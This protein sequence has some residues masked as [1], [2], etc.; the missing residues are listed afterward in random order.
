MTPVIVEPKD[1]LSALKWAVSEMDRRYKLFAEVGVKNIIGY[2][3]MSGFSALPFLLIVI[4]EL[5]DIMHFAPAEVEDTI[6]RIAQM[7]RATGIHLVISTQRPSVDVITGLIKANISCRLAFNVSSQIDSRVILDTPG[8]EK[9]LG[10]GDMLFI[11]PDQ[12]K[13]SRIQGTFIS[14]KE[15]QALIKFIKETG[16]TPQYTDEV[17][18]MADKKITPSGK[19]TSVEETERDEFFNQAVE[20]I[21]RDKRASASLFQR[22][23]K[24]GYARAARIIDQLEAAGIVGAAEGSKSREILISSPQDYFN[25]QQNES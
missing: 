23:L 25:R 18:E 3:E 4:D 16:V 12:A 1:V 15:T 24:L 10:K 20:I 8:A 22:R 14:D 6:C 9:L 11:P 17:T 19:I 13:P 7:A 21:C 2:N 5:A